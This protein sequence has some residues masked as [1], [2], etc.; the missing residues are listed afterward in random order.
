MRQNTAAEWYFT[1]FPAGHES[2]N[3]ASN[4]DIHKQMRKEDLT[5]S[6]SSRH[7]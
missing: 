7:F 4:A 2:R 6:T 5:F 3:R 1:I